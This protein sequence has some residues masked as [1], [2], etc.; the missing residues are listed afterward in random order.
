MTDKNKTPDY[1]W[2]SQVQINTALI[3]LCRDLH[4]R[5]KNLK[6]QLLT[7]VQHSRKLDLRLQAVEQVIARYQVNEIKITEKH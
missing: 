3:A 1:F 5:N 7:V 4:N 2:Q 6:K